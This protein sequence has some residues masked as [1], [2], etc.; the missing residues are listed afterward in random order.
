M[1]VEEEARMNS[2]LKKPINSELSW[3]SNL[4][5]NESGRFK[6]V[7]N[8]MKVLVIAEIKKSHFFLILS[9]FADMKEDKVRTGKKVMEAVDRIFSKTVPSFEDI[10]DEE[11]FYFFA[12]CFT[13][14]SVV[15]AF[16]ASR[17]IT[18]KERD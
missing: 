17:Y 9:P 16:I 1:G 5:N 3:G 14:I 18:L 10:F 4:S 13:C 6:C 2:P 15:A 12:A 11:S 8:A 7:V